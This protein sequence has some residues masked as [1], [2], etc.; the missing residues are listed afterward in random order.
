MALFVDARIPVLFGPAALAGTEDA[1]LLET[2]SAETVQAAMLVER[3]DE[4]SHQ[5]HATGCVC[6]TSRTELGRLLAGL[7]LARARGEVGFFRR[8]IVASGSPAVQDAVRAALAQD[9]LASSC[10]RLMDPAAA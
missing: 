1:V 4:T 10:F 9:P 2:R 5:P 3:F 6:C 8:V 7:F